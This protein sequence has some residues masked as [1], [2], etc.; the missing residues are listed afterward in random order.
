VIS[1]VLDK[2]SEVKSDLCTHRFGVAHSRP[3]SFVLNLVQGLCQ[4]TRPN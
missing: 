2:I 4:L 1:P 3:G